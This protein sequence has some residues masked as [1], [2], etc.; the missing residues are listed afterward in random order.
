MR[1]VEDS[2][3]VLPV[4]RKVVRGNAVDLEVP[5]DL[6]DMVEDVIHCLSY[7]L[8][9]YDVDVVEDADGLLAHVD[10]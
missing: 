6:E 3:S 1:L 8:V 2:P 7:L 4:C 5:A 10:L 9:R